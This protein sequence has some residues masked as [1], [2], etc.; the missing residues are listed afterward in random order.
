MPIPVGDGAES[1]PFIKL[2]VSIGI[3]T[4]HGAS[5]ELTQLLAAAD[6]ALYHAKETG[7]NKT[8]MI[9]ATAA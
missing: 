7:R 4:M 1:G 3:A 9:T 5:C 8:H 6:A 2:T